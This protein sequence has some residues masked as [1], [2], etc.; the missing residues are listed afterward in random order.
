M[1]FPDRIGELKAALVQGV[2]FAV[3]LAS[4][5]VMRY[6][7]RRSATAAAAARYLVSVPGRSR[8]AAVN[9]GSH[10]LSLLFNVGIIALIGELIGSDKD[11]RLPQDE[12]RHLLLAGMRGT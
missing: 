2:A 5:G 10:F 4:I 8:Y 6:A 11:G 1:L 9:V 3:L 12:R 7:V